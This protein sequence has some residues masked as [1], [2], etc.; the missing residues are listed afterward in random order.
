[1]TDE[2]PRVATP[3]QRTRRIPTQQHQDQG[4]TAQELYSEYVRRTIIY[5]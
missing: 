3:S 4:R 2:P 1:M 5:R